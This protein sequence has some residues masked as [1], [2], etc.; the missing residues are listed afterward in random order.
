LL[1]T[2]GWLL[3]TLAVLLEIVAAL[4]GIAQLWMGIAPLLQGKAVNLRGVTSGKTGMPAGTAE[5]AGKL[6]K[7]AIFV[8]GK[9]F[10]LGCSRH[11]WLG[12][13][14]NHSPARRC[15]ISATDCCVSMCIQQLNGSME[16]AQFAPLFVRRKSH[17]AEVC[18]GHSGNSN[19]VKCG[20]VLGHIRPPEFPTHPE[21]AFHTLRGVSQMI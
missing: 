15:W 16:P 10:R 1:G 21:G 5:M 20:L 13:V 18:L 2:V 9:A 8:G 11:Y 6:R 19:I 4:L 7:A 3:K 14:F 17:H 12:R